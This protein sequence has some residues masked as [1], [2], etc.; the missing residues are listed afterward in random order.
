MYDNTL[1][2][3]DRVYLDPTTSRDEQMSFL[4][5][6]RDI[7]NK[8]NQQIAQENYNLGT[9]I[10]SNLGG[11]GGGA[12]EVWKGQYQRPQTN[13][14][15]ANLTTAAQQSVLNQ[16]MTNYQNMLL[17]RYNQAKRKKVLRG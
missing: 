7:Q 3:E 13:L 5:T 10:S 9:P 8:N 6:Y 2:F 14:A 4:D 12:R 11:L 1:E 16:A 15:I 17:N